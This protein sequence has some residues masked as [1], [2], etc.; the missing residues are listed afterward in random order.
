MK[1]N[2]T[3]RQR[4]YAGRRSSRTQKQ[5]QSQFS[6]ETATQVVDLLFVPPPEAYCRA[7]AMFSFENTGF[8]DDEQ[9]LYCFEF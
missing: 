6:A 2:K 9:K 4:R 1:I 3:Q 7:N 5:S 8:R